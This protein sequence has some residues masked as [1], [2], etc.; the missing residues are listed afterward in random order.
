MELYGLGSTPEPY[1]LWPT[2]SEGQEHSCLHH[3]NS[4]SERKFDVNP[5]GSNPCQHHMVYTSNLPVTNSR[6]FPKVVTCN[7]G[8]L[9]SEI[10]NPV[11]E[12][13]L[14]PSP[15]LRPDTFP[16]KLSNTIATNDNHPLQMPGVSPKVSTCDTERSG[17]KISKSSNENYPKIS[18]S[19]E[20][21]AGPEI[22]PNT[23]YQVFEQ[24]GL[25][26]YFA[27]IANCNLYVP[28]ATVLP[29]ES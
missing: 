19:P 12:I 4:K 13:S 1:S 8:S 16:E 21:C 6:S 29:L 3:I 22:L 17:G 11:N 25:K 14:E 9:G 24:K 28:D 15:S 26:A 18:Q 10:S 5:L 2:S 20:N 27:E 7:I 23:Y